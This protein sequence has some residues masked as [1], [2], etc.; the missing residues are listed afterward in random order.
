M[1]QKY[2]YKGRKFFFTPTP[3]VTGVVFGFALVAYSS[4]FGIKQL[5]HNTSLFTLEHIRISGLEYLDEEAVRNLAQMEIDKP[6]YDIQL[7]R[8]ANNFLKNK[9]VRAVS[10][11]RNIPSTLRID[12]QE[13]KPVM[14]MLDNALYMVDETG[15]I[16]QKLSTV[17]AKGLPIATGL[18][19]PELLKNRTPLYRGLEIINAI[20]EVDKFLLEFVS[21]VQLQKEGW[22]DLFLMKGGARLVL[23]D[24]HQYERIYAWSQLFHKTSIIDKLDQIKKIDFSFSDRIVIEYKS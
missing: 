13:R 14:F 1:K 15:M 12:I 21:E 9:Y 16:L 22:P 3:K 23:G 24:S 2:K 17:P 20:K 4:A 7:D 5:V 11:S 18:S 10:V 6:L 8:V 19:V